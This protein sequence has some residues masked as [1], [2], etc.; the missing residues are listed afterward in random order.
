MSK[1]TSKEL[2]EYYRE[3]YLDDLID[4]NF[5]EEKNLQVYYENMQ[6][7]EK[8]YE[9]NAYAY[10]VMNTFTNKK[11][12]QEFLNKYCLGRFPKEEIYDLF[13]KQNKDIQ[14]E[15]TEWFFSG[16]WIKVEPV[17]I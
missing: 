15:F 16:N 10:A 17:E 13:I 9:N 8:V 3:E 6:T 12:F 2:N 11:E 4:D 14:Q 1:L 7:K 5:T